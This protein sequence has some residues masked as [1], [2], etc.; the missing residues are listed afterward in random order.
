MMTLYGCI[1]QHEVLDMISFPMVR[2]GG[3]ERKCVARYWLSEPHQILNMHPEVLA[4][5]LA[6]NFR[7]IFT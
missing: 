1:Q 2:D 5:F 3:G 6:G 4:I 7:F